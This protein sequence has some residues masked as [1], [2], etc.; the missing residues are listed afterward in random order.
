MFSAGGLTFSTNSVCHVAAS[1]LV[2]YCLVRGMQ[3][4]SR[5]RSADENRCGWSNCSRGLKM[6]CC[7]V[8]AT[9]KTTKLNNAS[10]RRYRTRLYDRQHK[11]LRAVFDLNRHSASANLTLKLFSGNLKGLP[12]NAATS[13]KVLFS[14]TGTSQQR[15]GTPFGKLSCL[16]RPCSKEHHRM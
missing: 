3:T 9:A 12:I 15:A 14:L 10:G 2:K 7:I 6:L 5:R 4:P 8:A 13:G 16:C 1:R 11:S